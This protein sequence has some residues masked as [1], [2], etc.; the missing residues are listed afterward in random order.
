MTAVQK[1]DYA[2]AIRTLLVATSATLARSTAGAI[3]SLACACKY[4]PAVPAAAQA[5]A[6]QAG[7]AAPTQ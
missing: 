5:A 1:R 4:G 3:Y 7:P 2:V 6:P